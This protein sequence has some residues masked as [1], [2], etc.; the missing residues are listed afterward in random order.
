MDKHSS[1]EQQRPN[2]AA[3][4]QIAGRKIGSAHPAYIIAEAGVNHNGNFD[5]ALKLVEEAHK[6][7]AD[8]VKFQTFN[9]ESCESKYTL[10]PGYFGGR[11]RNADKIDFL[12]AL[13][14]DKEQFRDLKQ[15]CD[16]LGITFMSMAADYPSLELLVDIGCPAIKVGSSDTLNFPLFKAIGSSGLPVVYSTGISTLDD[17]TSGIA[18]L[19]DSGVRDICVLQC[20]SQYPAPV[21]DINLAV[22]DVY[23]REFQLPAGLSDHS[24]GLHIPI[25]A[26]ARGASVIEKHMTL[27]RMLPGVDHI[28]S[29]EPA[30]L[31][32]MIAWIRDVESAI[33]DG[34]KAIR[35][36][37]KEHLQSMRKS[38]FSLRNIRAGEV[39]T[40]QNVGAKRP[41]GGIM[42]TEIDRLLGRKAAV[43]I[44]NDEFIT[45]EMTGE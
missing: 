3:E 38:L 22:M 12:K 39:L 35:S 42:P 5:M 33:G 4:V 40:L 11:D 34:A 37:E 10:K 17:V 28:A 45:W 2:Q 41:G 44:D 19:R 25:A 14:F 16:E 6:A 32:Q 43:D 27:S 21:E 26:V 20:T 18:Y 13:E 24:E 8:C 1:T 36:S 31:R 30:E 7:G 29:I 23:R 9:T 15:Y